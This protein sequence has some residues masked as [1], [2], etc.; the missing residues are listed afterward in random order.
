MSL[1]GPF[2]LTNSAAN[3]FMKG[4]RSDFVLEV[5]GLEDLLQIEI[6]H[7]NKGMGAAWHLDRVTVDDVSAGISYTFA[8]NNWCG[9]FPLSRRACTS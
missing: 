2:K 7:D 6:G 5:P 9:L 4:R 8:Y 3:D 1:A